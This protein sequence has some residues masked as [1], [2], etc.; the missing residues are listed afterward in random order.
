MRLISL[1]V[2]SFVMICQIQG[3]Y[4]ITSNP[5][6]IAALK[7]K[8]LNGDILLT[9]ATHFFEYSL[10]GEHDEWLR[11]LSKDC[12]IQ[13]RPDET[14]NKWWNYLTN[15]SIK[16]EILGQAPEIRTNQKYI[17]FKLWSHDEYEGEKRLVL[18]RENDSWK[19][20]S[21]DL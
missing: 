8:S 21:I 19:V 11:L 2:F 20:N 3:Q 7:I 14:T 13:G 18:I 10:D 17:Y 5:K 9:T 1:L 12:F 16:Y 4:N 15:N 6:C